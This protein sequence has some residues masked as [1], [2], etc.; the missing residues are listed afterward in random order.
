METISAFHWRSQRG[1]SLI[2]LLVTIVIVAFGLVGVAG[3][4]SRMQLSE[5]EAYQRTQA[6]ILLN[7]MANRITVN[8]SLAA[9]YV[10]GELGAGMACPISPATRP[11]IDALEWCNALQ[12][13]AEVTSAG[14]SAGA[15]LGGRGCVQAL[16]NNEYMVTVAWQGMAPVSAPPASVTCGFGEYDGAAETGC[17]GDRCRRVVTTI[18]RIAA[19]D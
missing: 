6:L 9:E 17:I 15:M 2:E 14:D 12:G 8:R 5:V 4:Q 10:T 16:P 18:V 19:L 3:L 7:D 13:A 11:E 1:T